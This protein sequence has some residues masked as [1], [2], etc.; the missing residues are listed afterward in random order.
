MMWSYLLNCMATFVFLLR[1]NTECTLHTAPGDIKVLAPCQ[2]CL[3]LFGRTVVVVSGNATVQHVVAVSGS[4]K[5]SNIHELINL[6][7][8]AD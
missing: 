5:Q 2:P 6:L 8:P 4:A 1:Q 3:M 7:L